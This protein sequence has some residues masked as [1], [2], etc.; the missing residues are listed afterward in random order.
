MAKNTLARAMFNQANRSEI[1]N[2]HGLAVLNQTFR[3]WSDRKNH[4]VQRRELA[5]P[6]TM[7]RTLEKPRGTELLLTIPSS[8]GEGLQ[9]LDFDPGQFAQQWIDHAVLPAT[10][11]QRSLFSAVLAQ[12]GYIINEA[13]ALM[14]ENTLLF[15]REKSTAYLL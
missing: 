8:L 14:G 3:F 4:P 2:G 6:L 15:H 5:D 13:S 9:R 12:N 1:I 10:P 11:D 7:L